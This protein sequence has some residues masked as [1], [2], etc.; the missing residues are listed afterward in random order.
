M[1]LENI[2]HFNQCKISEPKMTEKLQGNYRHKH[3]SGC[4]GPQKMQDEKYNCKQGSTVTHLCDISDNMNSVSHVPSETSA[5]QNSEIFTSRTSDTRD[6]SLHPA[7]NGLSGVRDCSVK[8]D[9]RFQEKGTSSL[10]SQALT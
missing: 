9:A 5:V 6:A 1:P 8:C 2:S 4:M 10:L 3:H 7:N